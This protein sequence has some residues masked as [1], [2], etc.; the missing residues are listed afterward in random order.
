MIAHL[1]EAYQFDLTSRKHLP[2]EQGSLVPHEIVEGTVFSRNGVTVSAFLV[3]H[4]VWRRPSAIA[5]TT[6]G[7]ASCC[8]ATRSSV[9]T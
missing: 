2:P 4:G 6:V 1:T 8:Q 5:S 7:G 3:D 9:H